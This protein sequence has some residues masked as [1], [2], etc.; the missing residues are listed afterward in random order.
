MI[1]AAV[2]GVGAMGRHHA[3]V[4]NDMEGVELVAVVDADGERAEEIA[5]RYKV[6]PYADYREML[7][8][9][10]PEVVSV[11]VPTR[12]HHRVALDVMEKGV[13]L[14]IE[15]PIAS[16]V[17]EAEDII[18]QADERGLK[19]AVGHVER[20]NPAV[21]ELKKRLERRELGRVFLAHARRLGPF[22][23]RVRDMGVVI[24]LATHDLDVMCYLL[25]SKVERVYAE[26]TRRIHTQYEDLLSGLLRFKNGTIGVLNVNRLTP[27]KIRE[28][29]LTGERG[30]F[31]VNYLTQDLY[32]Y[33]ND[34]A[35]GGWESLGILKGVGEGNMIRLRIEKKEPLRAELE[36]FVKAVVGNRQPLVS[37]EDGLRA[38]VL[39]QQLIE[40]GQSGRVVEIGV[41]YR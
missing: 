34:Y 32:F 35:V 38:L 16:T 18:R 14:L 22:P 25:G 24:D 39:A 6:R 2:I 13:H 3:R 29:T 30:M 17:E 36:F 12:F 5:R 28:L 11:A 15:K 40:S 10:R 19:L 41:V 31:V 27:T 23:E 33:E 1:K 20:F 4:Y 37:G 8:Q 9:E 26:T 21:I 7:E